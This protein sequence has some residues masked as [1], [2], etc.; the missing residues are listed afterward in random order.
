MCHLPDAFLNSAGNTT[1]ET[2]TGGTMTVNKPFRKSK[3]LP[4]T[5]KRKLPRKTCPP[6]FGQPRKTGQTTYYTMQR[7]NHSGK[8]H[9]GD[10]AD[11]SGTSQPCPQRMG[12]RVIKQT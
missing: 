12:Y 10:M 4:P 8:L 11:D 2:L 3:M 7:P 9:A 1:Q 6:P 5:K